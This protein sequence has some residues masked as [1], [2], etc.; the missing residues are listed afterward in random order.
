MRKIG[1]VLL[2]LCFALVP[3]FAQVAMHGHGSVFTVQ[4]PTNYVCFPV[5]ENGEGAPIPYTCT[6]YGTVVQSATTFTSLTAILSRPV[7]GS[8]NIA[9][10]AEDFTTGNNIGTSN[11]IITTGQ[12]A[13]SVAITSYGSVSAGDVI[14]IKVWDNLSSPTYYNIEKIS[15]VL[16]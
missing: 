11:C 1:S 10:I 16:Q 8:H 3:C 2:S 12:E 15:W 6:G 13:C 4:T 7:V 9:I 14:A 5:D